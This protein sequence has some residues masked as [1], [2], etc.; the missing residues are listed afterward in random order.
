MSS[1]VEG[2]KAVVSAWGGLFPLYLSGS[3]SLLCHN[4]PKNLKKSN[5]KKVC[6]TQGST[7]EVGTTA[8]VRNS[9]GNKKRKAE[10]HSIVLPMSLQHTIPFIQPHAVC[11]VCEDEGGTEKS[12]LL[13]LECPFIPLLILLLLISRREGAMNE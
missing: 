2:K 7:L 5:H 13:C 4:S 12:R 3:S 1:G 11:R 6:N 10:T 9:L 8:S